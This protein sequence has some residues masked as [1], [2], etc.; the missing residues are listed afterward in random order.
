MDDGIA[1]GVERDGL[2]RWPVAITLLS[3]FGIAVACL[4]MCLMIPWCVDYSYSPHGVK[5]ECLL[6]SV[7]YKHGTG[8]AYV[9]SR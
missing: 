4:E 9:L 2:E 8:S 3:A 7:C 1:L 6:I 5:T